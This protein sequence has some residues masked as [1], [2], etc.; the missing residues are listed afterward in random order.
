MG[1]PSQSVAPPQ[2]PLVCWEQWTHGNIGLRRHV[3]FSHGCRTVYTCPSKG[4]QSWICTDWKLRPGINWG[5]PNG[6]YWICGEKAWP[7]LPPGWIG[8]CSLGLLWGPHRFVRTLESPK[9]GS[10]W[11]QKIRWERSIFHN[12]EYA[13]SLLPGGGIATIM[14]KI[15][16]FGQAMAAALNATA[17]ALEAIGA[18]MTSMRTA[19]L[20]HRLALDMLTAA[21][22]GMCTLIQQECC[23]YIPD[24]E[25][26]VVTHTA[27]A[28]NKQR[29]KIH[30]LEDDSDLAPALA[31]L[32]GAGGWW[33]HVLLF[34][35]AVCC[36]LA[37]ICMCLYCFCICCVQGAIHV[38]P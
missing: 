26:S 28:L 17:L 3:G 27:E 5:A 34:A 9:I 22:G 32:Q 10:Y 37:F 25:Q 11:A 29:S 14:Y 24:D 1:D 8:R 38:C 21:S 19:V 16:I 15:N 4:K 12:A 36:C 6:S 35:V 18:E 2:R 13:W 7:W 23:L 31:W 30:H 20:Q 33:K